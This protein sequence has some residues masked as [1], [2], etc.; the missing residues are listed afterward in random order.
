LAK[1]T[2][3]IQS[4]F[5]ADAWTLSVASVMESLQKSVE[6]KCASGRTS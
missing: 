4:G 2:T 6:C 5:E 1:T 3:D